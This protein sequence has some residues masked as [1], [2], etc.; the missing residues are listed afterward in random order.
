M[1][2]ILLLIVSVTGLTCCEGP[3]DEEPQKQT[4]QNFANPQKVG[5]L[6]DG[7]V[8][9]VVRRVMGSGVHDHYIYFVGETITTNTTIPTGKT[10]YNQT[11]VLINGVE[12]VKK[13]SIK[14]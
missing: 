7:R 12:Y 4:E 6:P 1:K 13:D 14:N 10:S 8:V 11:T 3:F 5:T 2:K 9:N